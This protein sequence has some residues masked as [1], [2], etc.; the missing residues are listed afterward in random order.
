MVFIEILSRRPFFGHFKVKNVKER[1]DK[2]VTFYQD[3]DLDN[4]NVIAK[5]NEEYYKIFQQHTKK[6]VFGVSKTGE[7][8]IIE[9][10]QYWNDYELIKKIPK[11]Q[12]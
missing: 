1:L 9:F 10:R 2:Y 4:I 12:F 8:I 5:K 11:R 6:G 7:P 3:Y